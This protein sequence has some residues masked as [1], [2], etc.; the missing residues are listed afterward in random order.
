MDA[1]I[2]AREHAGQH[3]GRICVAAAAATICVAF[4]AA[5]I[6]VASGAAALSASDLQL[7]RRR[8][9]TVA[10]D[11]ADRDPADLLARTPASPPC[12]LD[13]ALSGT[14]A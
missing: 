7:R 14:G 9:E 2:Q 8:T 12:D 1:G 13:R 11:P 4:A 5:A 10:A 3:R 6:C